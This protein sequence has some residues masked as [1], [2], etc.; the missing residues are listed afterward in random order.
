MEKADLTKADFWL[1]ADTH[2]LANPRDLVA[3]SEAGTIQQWSKSEP[4]L[5][6]HMLFRTSGSTGKGKWVALS[7]SALLASARAVNDFLEVTAAD[8]WLLTLPLFHV[9][10]VGIAARAYLSGSMIVRTSEKWEPVH[11]HRQLTDEKITLT[12]LV[13]AQLSDLVR[14]DLAAP[15]SLR[16]VLIG[17]GR[18]DDTLYKKATELE[19]P[20]RETYGMTETA[21]QVATAKAGERKLNVLPCWEV[22]ENSDGCLRVKGEALFTGYVGC[23]NDSCFLEEPHDAEGWFLTN[24]RGALTK[25]QLTIQG[26]ADRCVKIL[27]ELVDLNEVEQTIHATMEALGYSYQELAVMAVEPPT[28]GEYR[29]VRRGVLLV[30]CIEQS[31]NFSKVLECYNER[32]QPLHRIKGIAVLDPL[33]RTAIGKI[34]YA[35]LQQILKSDK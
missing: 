26:R 9:G 16:A 21:S 4:R 34:S 1:S 13:P 32:C 19:W 33:P 11:C 18:L 29:D 2:V 25:G 3:C 5:S 30:V 12:S 27:G 23:E 8:R 20:V 14:L 15:E 35:E 17:G 22:F 24:D 31:D 7:K 28:T 10:G 6:G